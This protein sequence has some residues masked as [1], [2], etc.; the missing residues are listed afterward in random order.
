MTQKEE[1]ALIQKKLTSIQL[2]IEE[3]EMNANVNREYRTRRLGE[4]E[5]LEQRQ[6]ER[7]EEV[8]RVLHDGRRGCEEKAR[9]RES[10]TS[11]NPLRNENS[12]DRRAPP[13]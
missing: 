5:G 4:P 10:Q 1:V 7:E 8:E 3:C 13:D 6:V 12:R 9:R 2:H 11:A